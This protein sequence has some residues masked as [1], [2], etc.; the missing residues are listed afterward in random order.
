[1]KSN[2]IGGFDEVE[3]VDLRRWFVPAGKQGM[4]VGDRRGNRLLVHYVI[5]IPG[6]GGRK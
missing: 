3:Y 2:L 6:E 1:M 4:E 5:Q